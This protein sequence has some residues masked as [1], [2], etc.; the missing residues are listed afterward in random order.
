MLNNN[1]SIPSQ[2]SAPSEVVPDA[3]D[4][5]L[6][7]KQLS[8]PTSV[9]LSKTDFL[10]HPWEGGVGLTIQMLVLPLLQALVRDVGWGRIALT[11][12]T[13]LD[14]QSPFLLPMCRWIKRC[15]GLQS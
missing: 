15:S 12:P 9:D 2:L 1:E 6:T 8:Q 4:L 7:L 10:L 14:G 5:H 13:H 11:T 3:V